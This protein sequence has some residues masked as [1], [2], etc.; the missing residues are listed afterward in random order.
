[1]FGYLIP[2]IKKPYEY[3]LNRLYVGVNV[4]PYTVSFLL[5]VIAPRKII[6][7][8]MLKTKILKYV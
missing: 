7:V 6:F 4:N 5:L 2:G 8:K 1:M 3:N